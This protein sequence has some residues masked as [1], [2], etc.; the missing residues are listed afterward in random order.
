MYNCITSNCQK[1]SYNNRNLIFNTTALGSF[2][3]YGNEKPIINLLTLN[4]THESNNTYQNLTINISSTDQNNDNIKIIYNWILNNSPILIVNMPFEKINNSQVNNTYD[5]S[6][7][8]NHA[9]QS[10]NVTWNSTGGYDGKGAYEFNG[11]KVYMH[12]IENDGLKLQSQE[13]MSIFS[14]VKPKQEGTNQA[15]FQNGFS[16][17]TGYY[18][19]YRWGGWKLQKTRR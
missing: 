15:I 14:W 19:R 9:I 3:G 10:G 11:T 18:M 12:I 7:N 6:R 2:T 1:Q 8:A 4:S 16:T 5:Y 13:N 17:G